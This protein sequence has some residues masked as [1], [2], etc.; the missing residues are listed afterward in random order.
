[1]SKEQNLDHLRFVYK[2]A[3]DDWV[4]SIRAE[5]DMAAEDH[6][7][8]AMKE[9]DAAHLREHDAHAKVTAAREAYKDALRQVNYGI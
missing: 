9:W 7:M 1:M 6:S 2:K 4:D 3:V 5:E 8:K